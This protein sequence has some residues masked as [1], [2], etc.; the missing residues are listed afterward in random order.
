MRGL[1]F[2]RLQNMYGAVPVPLTTDF[3]TNAILGRSN[4]VTVQ[5]QVASDWR[6]AASLLPE[7]YATGIRLRPTRYAALALLSRIYLH[8]EKWLEAEE[9]AS[10][11]IDSGTGLELAD[12]PGN[13]FSIGSPEVIW[14]LRPVLANMNTSTAS[15][16]GQMGGTVPSFGTY[17]T[18]FL[19]TM[20]TEDLRFK[21]WVHT[22]E[23]QGKHYW[24][25]VKYRYA[26]TGQGIEYLVM[27]RLG[28]VYLNRA[29]ARIR[30]SKFEEAKEDINRIRSRAGLQ[31]ITETTNL[32][33]A[34]QQERQWELQIE[35]DFRW[36]DLK[37]W[38]LL[39]SVIEGVKPGVWKSK[40]VFFPIPQV[41]INNNKQLVQNE[42][43]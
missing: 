40:A 23:L 41:E 2:Y 3:R 8:Q 36:S 7:R 25:P 4:Q 12:S 19:A 27:V 13:V 1:A 31:S 18:T 15:L 33:N 16:L 17:R 21:E 39:E 14:Q 22:Y 5:E 32:F 6:L 37:R 29:E 24:Q 11:V 34:L 10:S 26:N 9:A 28:E 38:G 30:L 43:Y 42:G 35:Q 20:D